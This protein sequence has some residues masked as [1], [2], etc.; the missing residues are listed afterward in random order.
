MIR[1]VIVQFA[2]FAR[3]ALSPIE[4]LSD[5]GKDGILIELELLF[6]DRTETGTDTISLNVWSMNSSLRRCFQ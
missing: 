6:A 4:S 5:T 2:R 1:A 3:I